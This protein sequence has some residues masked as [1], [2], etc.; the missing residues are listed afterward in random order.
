MAE[1]YSKLG[2]TMPYGVNMADFILD[3]ASGVVTTTKLDGNESRLH[4]IACAETYLSARPLGYIQGGDVGE[5]ELGY[6]LFNSAQV[7]PR[8]SPGV[9]A[10]LLSFPHLVD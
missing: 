9:P 5:A 2:Y 7:G 3:L 1:W 10:Y 8:Q 6:Q 4:C